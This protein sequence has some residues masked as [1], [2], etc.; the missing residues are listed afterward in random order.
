[1]PRK[2]AHPHG[3]EALRRVIHRS[4]TPGLKPEYCTQKREIQ[5][6]AIAVI[7]Q[8]RQG[9]PAVQHDIIGGAD[10]PSAI[11]VRSDGKRPRIRLEIS[12]RCQLFSYRYFSSLPIGGR[13]GGFG[14]K[15]PV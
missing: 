3:R 2:H 14:L 7:E 13:T 15:L 9:N 1:M 6:L 10:I 8:D 4:L 12:N 11:D 5:D